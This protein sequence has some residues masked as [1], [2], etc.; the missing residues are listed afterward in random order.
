MTARPP[1]LSIVWM[2]VATL[3][4]AGCSALA[5][6]LPDAR[7]SGTWSAGLPVGE[8]YHLG[9]PAVGLDREGWVV[10]WADGAALFFRR[11]S[12]DGV[13][14][15]PQPLPLDARTPWNPVLLP[16]SAHGWHLLWQDLDRFGDA[17][18]FSARL[19]A[20]GTVIR[21]PLT[22][23][24]T[25]AGVVAAAP[26][27][28]NGVILVWAEAQPRPS[29]YGQRLDSQGR[30]V[31]GPP[32]LIAHNAG[33]PALA[34]TGDGQWLL[35]WLALPD[36]PH[37]VPSDRIATVRITNSPLPWEGDA[38]PVI[39][40]RI[41][42]SDPVEYLETVP[43]GLDGT[44]GYLFVSRRSAATLLPRTDVLVFSLS[45]EAAP[46]PHPLIES[47]SLPATLPPD[48][49]AE[50]TTGYNTGGAIPLMAGPP[51]GDETAVPVGWPMPV[52]GQSEVLAVAFEAGGKPVVGYFQ[53][54]ALVGYQPIAGGRALGALGLWADRD[55]HL[56][57]AWAEQPADNS[58]P[59]ILHLSSTRAK[60][61]KGSAQD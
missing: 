11:V 27:G 13:L 51:V 56:T 24:H 23:S 57:I 31:A 15:T 35:S 38:D 53:D 40:G 47:V 9:A 33:W 58:G 30:P 8:A 26:G 19:D 14:S 39:V 46:P 25:S 1:T 52:R 6:P 48:T 50:R 2:L 55:R 5:A 43:L 61:S 28:G 18:L 59:A 60:L 49:P 12:P 29:L 7:A 54:G 42:L 20:A 45:A 44:Y 37:D 16:A 22:V 36:S 41:D 21:G 34:Q 3:C 10:V 32:T 17:Q 4:L